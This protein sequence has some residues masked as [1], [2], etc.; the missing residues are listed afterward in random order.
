MECMS[1]VQSIRHTPFA[2]PGSPTLAPPSAAATGPVRVKA[3]SKNP[4]VLPCVTGDPQRSSPLA[5]A[6]PPA[7]L[8]RLLFQRAPAGSSAQS[9]AHRPLQWPSANLARNSPRSLSL[10]STTKQHRRFAVASSR[11]ASLPA[12]R[13]QAAPGANGAFA[14]IAAIAPASSPSRAAAL[15]ACLVAARPQPQL[16]ILGPDPHSAVS[17]PAFSWSAHYP[18]PNPMVGAAKRMGNG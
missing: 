9:T 12:E 14:V 8:Q 5:P 15:L 18:T 7:A 11:I 1:Q 4:A 10:N 17:P 6:R 3:W 13:G 2:V 16:A